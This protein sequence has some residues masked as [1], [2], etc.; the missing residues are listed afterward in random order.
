MKILIDVPSESEIRDRSQETFVAKDG[1]L[2]SKDSVGKFATLRGVYV[3]CAGDEI[4]YVGKTTRGGYGTFGERLR[5]E[6]QSKS[7][8]DWRIYELLLD[9]KSV[10]TAFITLDEI[11]SRICPRGLFVDDLLLLFQRALIAAYQPNGNI[12]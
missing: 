1:D 6:C 9:Q 10:R 7:A 5:R 11:E 4:L 12:V 8:H 3:H 2:W